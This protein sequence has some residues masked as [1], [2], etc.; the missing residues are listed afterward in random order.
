MKIKC[1]PRK[2]FEL[3]KGTALEAQVLDQNKVVFIQSRSGCDSAECYTIIEIPP[4]RMFELG[5]ISPKIHCF[6]TG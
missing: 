5:G 3:I 4:N 1:M 2:W 6:S